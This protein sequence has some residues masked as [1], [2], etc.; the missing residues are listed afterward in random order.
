MSKESPQGEKSTVLVYADAVF[1]FGILCQQRLCM[2]LKLTWAS[3]IT[4]CKSTHGHMIRRSFLQS[5]NDCTALTSIN[6]KATP[7]HHLSCTATI[8]LAIVDKIADEAPG[9]HQC[10]R[11]PGH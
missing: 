10:Q 1:G 8:L 7:I 5:S 11:S 3:C 6:N 4:G 2:L 9:F